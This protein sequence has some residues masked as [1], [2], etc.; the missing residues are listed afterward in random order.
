MKEHKIAWT[1]RTWNPIVGCEKISAG[2]KNCYAEKM[3]ARIVKMMPQFVK[4]K[5]GRETLKAY[6][7]VIGGGK[8][9]GEIRI[10]PDRIKEPLSWRKPQ[11][12]FVNSMSDLFHEDIPFETIDDILEIM[13][14]KAFHHTYQI[15]TKRPER[16]LEYFEWKAKQIKKAGYDSLGGKYYELPGCVWLGVT[17]EDKDVICERLT[18]LE[19]APAK[20]KFLSIEPLLEDLG[21][22]DL[23]DIDWVIIG[24]ESGAKRRECEIEWVEKLVENA[25]K[26]NTKVF[27]KQLSINGKVVKDIHK[28]PKHLRNRDFPK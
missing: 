25:R 20:V 28:F 13:T 11:K 10:L 18:A 26:D 23:T 7:D 27:V 14:A 4:T 19:L 22:I 1:E 3:S 8:F 15:L 5:K 24:C 21:G 6:S 17:I 2:C 9:N 16:M 12:V